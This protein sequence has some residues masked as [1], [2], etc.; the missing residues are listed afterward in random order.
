MGRIYRDLRE[1]PMPSD[2]KF[3]RKSKQVSKYYQLNGS[4]RRIVV[5][6]YTEDGK[7]H[8]NDNFRVHYPELWEKYY[9]KIDPLHHQVCMGLYAAGLGIGHYTGLYP[10]PTHR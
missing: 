4:R 10:G 1:I 5:G 8:V 2:T 7:M 9:G 6:V 3:N